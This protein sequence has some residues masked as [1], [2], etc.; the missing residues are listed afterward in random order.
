[1][2][3]SMVGDG[4]GP[5]VE[6]SPVDETTPASSPPG[7]PPARGRKRG[8]P[9]SQDG[10]ALLTAA[11][12]KLRVKP[13]RVFLLEASVDVAAGAELSWDAAAALAYSRSPQVVAAQAAAAE[14]ER[15]PE[16][17]AESG[18]SVLAAT[19]EAASGTLTFVVSR[20]EDFVGD[21]APAPAP[22]AAGAS[23]AA[24]GSHGGAGGAGEAAAA[25]SSIEGA[26]VVSVV[27][28]ELCDS[29]ALAQ[30]RSCAALPHVRVA[31][32]MPDLHVGVPVPIGAAMAVEAHVYPAVIGTDIGCGV[33]L[34]RLTAK[35]RRVGESWATALE[36]YAP[37][38]GGASDAPEGIPETLLGGDIAIRDHIGALG[39]IGRGNHFAELQ[40]VESVVDA[41]R[42]AELGVNED[43]TYLLVHSGSRTLGA[44]V[45]RTFQARH[46]AAGAASGVATGSRASVCVPAA[47]AEG[48]EYLTAHDVA[49]RWGVANREAIARNICAVVGAERS[50]CVLDVPHNF[51]E[52]RPFP[53]N[54]SDASTSGE[55]AGGD[56]EGARWL[57]CHRKGAIPSDAGPVV[58]PGSRGA[59]SY[60]VEDDGCG[61]EPR[62]WGVA[63]ATAADEAAA[64]A[65]PAGVDRSLFT[66][67]ARTCFSLPHG[68][69]RKMSRSDAAKKFRRDTEALRKTDLGSFVVCADKALLR[70]E[71][72]GSYKDIEGVMAALRRE[73]GVKVI[74]VL[75]PLVTV[76][77]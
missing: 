50:A 27:G 16:A 64:A 21:T 54:F 34:E 2:V 58:I 76:K 13:A 11:K 1:M 22:P 37:P 53:Q 55:A 6:A 65:V 18:P 43:S 23:A 40:A 31:A 56:R 74:A 17:A 24:G 20:G 19:A 14:A 41:E 7:G 26:G 38:A 10:R 15:P 42:C 33:R 35:A 47:S 46:D 67:R 4:A 68:A 39:S 30:L 59:F 57:W 71:A 36:S 49:V 75:R 5:A 72:P 73:Y 8:G 32:G 69:G 28:V 51:V 9:A 60:L 61:R 44:A 3:V 63:G 52:R 48:I 62:E 25:A 45:Q 12:N 66:R 77:Q 29:A 70:E